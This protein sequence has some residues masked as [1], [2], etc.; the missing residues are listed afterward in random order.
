MPPK[1]RTTKATAMMASTEDPHVTVLEQEVIAIEATSAHAD[2]F[3]S[4]CS[5]LPAQLSEEEEEDD[6][7]L[8][9]DSDEGIDLQAKGLLA[10]KVRVMLML[11]IPHTL[12][13]E[14]CAVEASVRALQVYL[15]KKLLVSEGALGA[16]SF[17][18]LL[19]TWLSRVR[20]SRLHV[21]FASLADA[22]VVRRHLVDHVGADGKT[23]YAFGW[24]HPINSR[25][26][27]AKADYRKE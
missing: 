9:D 20:Y 12:A 11:L 18:E 27:K 16:L 23:R 3:G 8:S 17:Q 13:S 4:R 6:R 26:L 1:G 5:E 10:S 2:P 22:E 15:R 21:T 24:Q 7:Y 19:P 25:F 14:V